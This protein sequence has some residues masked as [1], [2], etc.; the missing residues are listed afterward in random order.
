MKKKLMN[1]GDTEELM[2]EVAQH[3]QSLT[4]IRNHVESELERMCEE[5]LKNCTPTETSKDAEQARRLDEAELMGYL[6]CLEPADGCLLIAYHNHDADGMREALANGANPNL[7]LIWFGAPLVVDAVQCGWVQ[8]ADILLEAGADP[9]TEDYL[10]L[11]ILC[12]HGPADLLQRVLQLPGVSPDYDEGTGYNLADY[13]AEAGR[14]DCLRVLRAAGADMLA[15]EGRTLCRACDANQPEVVRYLLEECG[16]ALEEEYDD[17]SPLFYAARSNALECARILL[18][19][20]AD[21]LHRDIANGT[22]LGWAES[23]A[24]Q[25]LLDGY[26]GRRRIGI[27]NP[28]KSIRSAN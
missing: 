9:A 17:W 27:M 7:R 15:N 2:R 14:V 19:A 11:M 4:A 3:R 20:G 21:P 18:A 23:P 12:E 22:P 25:S 6:D 1:A 10:L 26:I 16:A 13:A 24:M 8:A 5:N 28:K